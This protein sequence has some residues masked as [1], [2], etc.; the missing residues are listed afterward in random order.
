MKKKDKILS[1]YKTRIEKGILDDR[2]PPSVNDN[3][4]AILLGE[5]QIAQLELEMQNDEL[6]M[7][8]ALLKA[9]RTKFEGFFNLAPT[10]YF[11]VDNLGTVEEVNQI[12]IKFIG[13]PKNNMLGQRVQSFIIPN[14]LPLFFD[15][16]QRMLPGGDKTEEIIRF[17]S[18]SG[19]IIH[20]RV[21]GIARVDSLSGKVQFYLTIIDITESRLLELER[22][23]TARR[24]ELILTASGIGTWSFAPDT[25]RLFLD[26]YSLSLLGIE[27]TAFNG[28]IK[29]FFDLVH[30]EDK[31]L[32]ADVLRSAFSEKR[33]VELEFR[34]IS[35]EGAAKSLSLKGLGVEVGDAKTHIA[36]IILDITKIKQ[37]EEAKNQLDKERQKLIYDATFIA[38]EKERSRISSTLHDSV[39]QLLYGIRLHLQNI[40]L[41]SKVPLELNKVHQLIAQAI[42][43]TR[44]LSYELTPSVLRDFGLVSAITEMTKRMSTN[45]F[46]ISTKISAKADQLP[47]DLQ[48]SV[49]RIIQELLNNCMKHARAKSAEITLC[50]EKGEITLVVEDNG[51]GIENSEEQMKKGSG[52]RSIRHR[53]LLLNGTV[54]IEGS[55]SGTKVKVKIKI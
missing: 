36:G 14:D 42:K 35:Q 20:T 22:K 18:Q 32:V 49:F 15:F 55:T 48:L 41:T 53:V 29:H 54:D 31:Q 13:L 50:A 10:G 45:S 34:I 1:N 17:K 8:I 2:Q 51:I 12:A 44:D 38:Q 5:L 52:L 26:Q 6:S 40:E 43:E 47:A 11:I 24:L 33:D 21:E 27:P 9:E 4:E 19:D 7:A 25:N 46:R 39:G 30:K 37:V 3:Q 16:L 23:N 28:N